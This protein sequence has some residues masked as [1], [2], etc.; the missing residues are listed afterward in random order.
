MTYQ[1][2]TTGGPYG[3]Y[4]QYGP[5]T[6]YPYQPPRGTNT[7]AILSL[8]FAF[9]F[10]PLGIYFGQRAK[11]EIAISHEDGEGLATAGIVVGWVG[12]GLW[13]LWLLFVIIYFVFVVFIFGVVLAGSAGAAGSTYALS[14]LTLLS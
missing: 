4:G 13:A 11:K 3:Q 1:P 6:P 12:V 10:A 9:V 5:G 8:V 2:P 7:M 14:F